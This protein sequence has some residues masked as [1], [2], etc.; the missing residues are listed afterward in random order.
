MK[1]MT[2]YKLGNN[3]RVSGSTKHRTERTNDQPSQTND[4][5]LK[6]AVDKQR[7]ERSNEKKNK[8]GDKGPEGQTNKQTN[9]QMNK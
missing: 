1:I 2:K 3:E 9:E 8:E 4:K 7:K 5:C 6:E